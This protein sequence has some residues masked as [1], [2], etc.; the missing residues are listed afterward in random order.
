MADD[1][2]EARVRRE[3]FDNALRASRLIEVNGRQVRVEHRR[4]RAAG[5]RLR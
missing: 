1:L 3:C 5:G 4:I 2:A